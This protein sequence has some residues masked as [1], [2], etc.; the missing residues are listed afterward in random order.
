MMP[1]KPCVVIDIKMTLDTLGGI[2][3]SLY[4][5]RYGREDFEMYGNHIYNTQVEAEVHWAICFQQAYEAAL[6]NP[7][8]LHTHDYEDPYNRSIDILARYNDECPE[9]LL[10]YI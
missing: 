1:P 2:I 3:Q 7:V 4:I 6:E 5:L 9:I 10:K 8:L